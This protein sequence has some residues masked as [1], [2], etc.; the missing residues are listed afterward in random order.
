MTFLKTSKFKTSKLKKTNSKKA[1]F[2]KGNAAT[3]LF[4]WLLS[5]S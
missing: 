2:K 3:L 4:L 5:C 1:N